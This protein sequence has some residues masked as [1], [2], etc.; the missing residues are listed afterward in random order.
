M[1]TSYPRM[2][3]AT[4][5]DAGGIAGIYAPIVEATPISFEE[6][7]P[8]ADEMR[9]RIEHTTQTYPW[10][11]TEESGEILGYAYGSKHRER[12]AYRWSV[13]VTAYVRE[14]ARDRRIGSSLYHALFRV[15]TAQG[16]HTAFAGIALPNDASIALHRSVGFTPVGVFHAIGY[17]F[18]AWHDVSWW[19][20]PLT[21]G[22]AAPH[23]PIALSR[24]DPETL[25]ELLAPPKPGR[26]PPFTHPEAGGFR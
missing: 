13:E 2:R 25:R 23:E 20:R 14:S 6:V 10:L 22:S 5:E 24:L 3:L 16:F 18:G 4:A 12:A 9:A 8:S 26:R 11:V 17:K 15:L 21:G 1:S 19:E 7:A